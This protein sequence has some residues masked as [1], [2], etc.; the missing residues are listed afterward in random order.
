ML[1]SQARG[2][3]ALTKRCLTPSI[4]VASAS[5]IIFSPKVTGR[6][7]LL[8]LAAPANSHTSTMSRLVIEDVLEL[9]GR[10]Q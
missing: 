4:A 6:Q 5:H 7:R 3:A 10:E 1:V 8:V 9:P 2:A